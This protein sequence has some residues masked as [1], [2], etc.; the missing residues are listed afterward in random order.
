MASI[1][2]DPNGN[3]TVQF[4]G[5]DKKRRSVRL[6]KA[7]QKAAEHVQRIVEH[8]GS[9]VPRQ[10]TTKGRGN[11]SSPCFPNSVRSWRTVT[12]SP[13]VGAVDCIPR[14]TVG[15]C[16]S[17]KRGWRAMNLRTM[18]GRIIKRAGLKPSPRLWHAL[19][20]SRQTE[21]AATFPLQMVCQWLGNSRLITQE[22]YLMR[23]DADFEKAVSTRTG[24]VQH[25]VARLGT[26]PQETK[27][28]TGSGK[29]VGF[30]EVF[31]GGTG[32]EPV[33]S[34]V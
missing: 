28:P 10:N 21:L 15:D 1:S 27:K 7:S 11:A 30:R 22:H 33:T 32:F 2:R 29:S 26:A 31:L 3:R 16:W 25:S 34:T 14:F 12:K 23:T 8:L 6:G 18:L 5:T 4:V 19:R 13:P 9:Q 24:A 17:A 20:A